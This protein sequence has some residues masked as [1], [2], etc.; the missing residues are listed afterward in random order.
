MATWTRGCAVAVDVRAAPTI[1]PARPPRRTSLYLQTVRELRRDPFAMAAIV[2]LT[3]VLVAAIAGPLIM[4]ADPLDQ[5]LRDR[6]KPPIW[7]E[8]GTTAHLFGTDQ[9]GRDIFSRMI[10]GA[11]ISVTIGLSIVVISA[12]IGTSLGLLSGFKRGRVEMIIGTV[13]DVILSF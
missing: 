1:L 2:V 7:H 3:L 12:V 5:S 4:P 8:G 9:L 6:L 11:R 13:T 10:D